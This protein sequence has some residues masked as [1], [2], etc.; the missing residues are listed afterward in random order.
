MEIEASGIEKLKSENEELKRQNENLRIT[1]AALVQ[2]PGRAEIQRLSVY[3]AAIDKLIIS[4]PGF[5]PAW[6]TALNE[7]EQVAEEV[8]NGAKSFF[9]KIFPKKNVSIIDSTTNKAISSDQ[10]EK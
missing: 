10:E 7:A 6:Q 5:G 9:R 2:K 4:S 1:N 8:G 3:Q